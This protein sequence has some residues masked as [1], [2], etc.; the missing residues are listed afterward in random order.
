MHGP[1]LRVPGL[2]APVLVV[3]ALAGYL[4]GSHTVRFAAAGT[5][6]NGAPSVSAGSALLE[7]PSSWHPTSAGPSIPG[8]RISDQIM[9][10]PGGDADRAGLIGG[11]IA[12]SEG[13]P[14]PGPFLSSL[15]GAPATSVVNFV[16]GQAYVYTNL[17][18]PDYHHVLD[19]YVIPDEGNGATA[20]ACYAPQTDS[21]YLSECKR[22]VAELTLTGPSSNNLTPDASYE[23]G[24]RT[25]IE[26][27]DRER[28][29]LRSEMGVSTTTATLA[30]L[31]T[32]LAAH[33]AAAATSLTSLTPPPP[34]SVAQASLAS[35]LARAGV[36][37]R[38]LASAASEDSEADSPAAHQQIDEAEGSVEDALEDLA[39]LGYGSP[40]GA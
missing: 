18:I 20:L 5:R 9:L 8:L 10:A 3:L 19:L 28:A 37:Y 14:L 33:F 29:T 30:S 17:D 35:A 1:V 12:A 2:V 4:A 38:T 11:R 24:L 23:S 34:A 15:R 26:A 32:R 27:L 39:L 16:A 22:I 7:Y 25:L 36:A 21:A 13:N 40:A 6:S 31:S